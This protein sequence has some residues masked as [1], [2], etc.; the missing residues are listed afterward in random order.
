MAPL[1]GEAVTGL[2]GKE[3][4]SMVKMRCF[5]A[6]AVGLSGTSV[7]DIIQASDDRPPQGLMHVQ[8]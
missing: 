2:V 6:L 4:A 8:R 5:V 7:V 3:A 1:G